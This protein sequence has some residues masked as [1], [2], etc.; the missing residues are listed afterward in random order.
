[1]FLRTP[2]TARPAFR[3]LHLFLIVLI[4][5]LGLIGCAE[6]P[7]SGVLLPIAETDP[8]GTVVRVYAATNRERDENGEGFGS[9]PSF[10]TT[11]MF[12]DIS[13]PPVR[14]PNVVRYRS[15]PPKLT[16]EFLVVA[17]GTLSRAE[18]RRR[19]AQETPAGSQPG[20]Y[21]HG[22][23]TRFPEALLHLALLK[24]DSGYAGPAVL[25]SWPSYG[26]PLEYVADRQSAIFSRDALASVLTDTTANG[27]KAL[28]FA[29]SMGSW[30]SIEALR[31][32]KLQ[33]REDVLK[34]LEVILAAPDIDVMVFDQQM[35]TIGNMGRPLVVLV[36]RDDKALAVSSLI[37]TGR[38]R[39]GALSVDAP[40]VQNSARASNVRIIDI[41][42]VETDPI[43]HSRYVPLAALYTSLQKG[44]RGE[45]ELAV[46]GAYVLNT[47]TAEML[48]PV[49]AIT[50]QAQ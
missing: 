15:E 38:P 14:K 22:F 21:V 41:G 2:L 4:L 49:A 27:Q 30:L 25:F 20:I 43:G 50:R 35:R 18:F 12:Y 28:L 8:A 39:L 13:V 42:S 6:R 36:A 47:L 29:H 7:T 37:G 10:E 40:E 9:D 5:S 44:G 32:L 19:V 1:M 11:Y 24:A 16:S 45:N 46:A 26:H 33:G 31:T 17:S 23:N 34:R 3:T 48:R